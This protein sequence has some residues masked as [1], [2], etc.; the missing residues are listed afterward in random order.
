MARD[1]GKTP[2]VVILT[3]SFND[4]PKNTPT[5]YT[6]YQKYY[7]PGKLDVY[8]TTPENR[9]Y[10]A[11]LG[12]M[13]RSGGHTFGI[14]V[15]ILPNNRPKERFKVAPRQGERATPEPRARVSAPSGPTP[16]TDSFPLGW[17]VALIGL[18]A[19]GAAFA[20]LRPR[21]MPL[22]IAGSGSS[23]R[24]FDV[25]GNTTVRL[26]GEGSAGALDAYPLAGTK[27]TVATVRGGRGQFTL[28]A[29]PT[30]TARVYHNGLPLEKPSPLRTNMV[31]S[32][33]FHPY[34]GT[35]R[36]A[37]TYRMGVR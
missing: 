25:R 5:A 21:A 36:P 9:D 12:W 14:G 22:R 15:E 34:E 32:S 26:G 1:S 19:T 17:L 18:G 10:E 6:A 29:Q 20:L 11:L 35:N 8:P 3:D 23:A 37:F 30:S 2:F 16:G 33:N 13:Q 27:E 28:S 31:W 4:P 7:T 24:D